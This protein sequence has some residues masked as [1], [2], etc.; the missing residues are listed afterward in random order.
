MAGGLSARTD[1]AEAGREAG[2]RAAQG[3]LSAGAA[4]C[5]LAFVFVSEHHAERL[6]EVGEG[7]ARALGAREV[8]GVSCEAVI[9]GASELEGTPGVAVLAGQMPGVTVKR[10]DS[11]DL[12]LGVGL[13]EDA[14]QEEEDD[15][16][17][18]AESVGLERGHRATVVVFDPQ[19]TDMATML[20]AMNRGRRLLRERWGP[21][22]EGP[23]PVVGGAAAA[24]GRRGG[25]ALLVG[26]RV[27]RGGL[28]GVSLGGAL[29]CDAVVSRGC[30][31][32]GPTYVVT[33]AKGN[34]IQSLGGRPALAVIRAAIDA[35]S[36]DERQAL[37]RGLMLGL[38][39]DEYKERFGPGDFLI[40][41]LVNAY[42]ESGAVSVPGSVRV[43]QTVR[44]HLRDAATA[45]RDLAMLLDA[46]ALHGPPAGVLL[47]SCNGRG[48]RLF[49]TPSHDAGAV[50]RAF[51]DQSWLLAGEQRAKGGSVLLPATMLPLAGG[52]CAGEIGPVG[53]AGESW[54][55]G[56]TACAVMFRPG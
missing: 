34:I 36:E 28:A 33:G 20:A 15:I 2:E 18:L 30:R 55:H 26:G 24:S 43:G 56:H 46:Q 51:A 6:G 23:G 40:R 7:V 32:F 4:A 22:A 39:A 13:A 49:S 29:R 53:A 31:G 19:T 45:E 42:Q 16:L 52:H 1:A 37:S 41:P 11:G 50:Q 48:T 8:L 54:L 9:A 35:L 17:A 21:S 47:F 38:A 27:L 5:D 14:D 10:F 44:L 12:P 25:N 3:L